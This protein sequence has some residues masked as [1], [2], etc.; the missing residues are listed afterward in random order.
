MYSLGNIL[1]KNSDSKLKPMYRIF[2]VIFIFL[3]FI[4]VVGSIAIRVGSMELT[5]GE[6]NSKGV[7]IGKETFNIYEYA[8]AIISSLTTAVTGVL[9]LF[10]SIDKD[11]HL[12]KQYKNLKSKNEQDEKLKIQLEAELLSLE[13]AIDPII[14]DGEKRKI[15]EANLMTLKNTLK[16]FIRTK[17]ALHQQS[18]T[19][20]DYITESTK[21]LIENTSTIPINSIND[22]ELQKKSIKIQKERENCKE[23]I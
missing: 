6:F 11:Y 4:S 3:F 20:L 7:F 2:F 19:Y 23:V 12:E 10:F 15:A 13:Q 17:L 1:S 18:P 14:Y 21:K 5:Y 9:S 22:N 16:I 8:L